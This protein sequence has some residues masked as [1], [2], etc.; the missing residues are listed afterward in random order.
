MQPDRR[1]S[2]V[3]FCPVRCANFW[4][5]PPWPL[6]AMAGGRPLGGLGHL[7]ALIRLA[8]AQR[9]RASRAVRTSKLSP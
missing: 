5:V 2:N 9:S 4:L 8:A 6:D 7:R 3:A 1:P